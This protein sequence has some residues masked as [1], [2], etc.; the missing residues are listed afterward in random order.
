[1]L[2]SINCGFLLSVMRPKTFLTQLVLAL[3][4]LT[5]GVSPPD[6]VAQI[7]EMNFQLSI[8]CL[9]CAMKDFPNGFEPGS[10]G[11]YVDVKP[12]ED[13]LITP[14]SG[15]DYFYLS[16]SFKK[17]I[18]ELACLLSRSEQTQTKP[19]MN[20]GRRLQQGFDSTAVIVSS[21]LTYNPIYFYQNIIYRKNGLYYF[22]S[23]N[24][25]M[26]LV[27][28]RGLQNQNNATIVLPISAFPTR[29]RVFTNVM[30]LL[31]IKPIFRGFVTRRFE[32]LFPL[33]GL[34]GT[35]EQNA[36]R[37]TVQNASDL[38]AVCGQGF[39]VPG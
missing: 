31:L 30:A 15:I 37:V 3:I 27:A 29:E 38:F 6:K 22:Q 34:T 5:Q 17:F 24:T 35:F 21:V 1:M 26:T 36:V 14:A 4:T 39:C 2:W 32:S 18:C 12:T 16:Q 19:A 9:N 20:H 11:K 28:G 25:G 8:N 7:R 33:T 10:C 13:V 23:I